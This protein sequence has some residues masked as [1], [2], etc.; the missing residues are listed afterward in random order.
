MIL[1]DVSQ[2]ETAPYL[3]PLDWVGMQNI[4]LPL[5]I[6]E[7]GRQREVH[8]RAGLMV[9]LPVPQ[10]KGIHMSRLYRLLDDGLGSGKPLT[11]QAILKL[12]KGMIESHEDCGSTN[13][14]IEI[15]FDLLLRRPAL[16]SDGLGG[17][18]A[19]P[20]KL[21]A[22]LLDRQCSVTAE[23]VVLYSSTCPCSAALSRQLIQQGFL[24]EFADKNS[25]DAVEVAAW[26][27][28]NATLATPHSQRS[29]AKISVS[30]NDVVDEELGLASLIDCIENAVA[31]PVQT[32]VKRLDEQEFARLNGKNLMFVEDAAR[33]IGSA[34]AAYDNSKI[35]VRHLESLHPHDAVVSTTQVKTN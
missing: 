28:D 17:W 30:L 29:E 31:T 7:Q 19:Y 1:P 10:I 23:V 34:L 21:A 16:V 27:N 32:A 26:L 8:A 20:I 12:L 11:T 9:N 3:T 22:S 6:L 33:R 25:I 15:A 2:S 5:T 14:C 4:D 13:A 18:R 35:S 24:E